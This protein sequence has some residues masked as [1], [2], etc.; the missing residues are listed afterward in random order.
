VSEF[1]TE[2]SWKAMVRGELPVKRSRKSGMNAVGIK[3]QERTAVIDDRPATSLIAF[4][5][6]F[7]P[8]KPLRHVALD[9]LDDHDGVIHNP[10]RQDEAKQ[11]AL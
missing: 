10:D 9:C 5:R 6:R 1:T 8:T 2:G 4:D 7:A 11:G 3:T